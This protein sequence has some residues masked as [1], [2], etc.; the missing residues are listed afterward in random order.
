LERRLIFTGFRLDVA[1]ILR[2][3]SVSVLP[4]L[5]EGLSNVLLESMASGVPVVAT[6][7]GG[8]L[9]TLEDGVSGI[10]IPPKSPET[11]AEAVSTLLRDAA[12]AARFAARGRERVKQ[13]FSLD[14]MLQ[15][16][17]RLYLELLRNVPKTSLR[18]AA[19]L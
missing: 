13:H 18:K 6:S 2:E 8:N 1:S 12:L 17:Q 10:L 3:V 19:A 16:T 7:V 9:E 14:R 4:S 11:L 5:S 15:D